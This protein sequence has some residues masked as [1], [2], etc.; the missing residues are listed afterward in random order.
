MGFV[1]N[2]NGIASNQVVYC[3]SENSSLIKFY[4]IDFMLWLISHY[5]SFPSIVF[6]FELE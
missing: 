6:N 1:V 4:V 3:I 5:A 2:I